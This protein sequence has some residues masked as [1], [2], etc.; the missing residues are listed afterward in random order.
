[1]EITQQAGRILAFGDSHV[2]FWN[3]QN[4]VG[5]LQS[6]FRGLDLVYLGAPTAHNLMRSQFDPRPEETSELILPYLAANAHKYGCFIPTFGD[7]DCRV[8]IIRQAAR[9]GCS[10]DDAVEQ[11]IDRYF[12]FLDSLIEKFGVPCIVWGPPPSSPP[13]NFVFNP[14]FPAVGSI[15]ERNY[16]VHVFNAKL[17]AGAASRRNIAHVTLFEH[18]LKTDLVTKTAAVYDGAHVDRVYLPA[19]SEQ[20]K[21]ALVDLG[22]PHLLPAMARRWPIASTARLE[23][24]AIGRTYQT[25]SRLNDLPFRPF[26]AE[27]NGSF[28]FHTDLDF[29]PWLLIDLDF[30]RIIETVVVHN[31]SDCAER[32]RSMVVSLSVDC[33]VFHDVYAPAEFGIFGGFDNAL[34]I[35]TGFAAP[36]RFVRLHLR[37]KMCFHLDCVQILVRTFLE[38]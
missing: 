21:T 15:W 7:V 13:D 9:N 35:D 6:A 27:P 28:A 24:V 5:P 38:P 14:E 16:A 37:E 3:G 2:F 10:I 11:T 25:S 18:L 8:H 32:A 36:A 31:R 29:F 22:L 33:E 4:Q 26:E 12:R 19:A 20:I 30:A 17:A 23:N 34:V 1:M